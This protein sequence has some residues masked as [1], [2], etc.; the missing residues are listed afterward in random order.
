MLE[1]GIGIIAFWVIV[2]HNADGVGDP[3]DS[4]Q[5]KKYAL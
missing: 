3:R 4:Q 2:D 5:K 1:V